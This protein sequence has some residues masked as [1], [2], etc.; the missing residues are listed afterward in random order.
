MRG[1][2]SKVTRRDGGIRCGRAKRSSS[3]RTGLS[4]GPLR[5]GA[6]FLPTSSRPPQTQLGPTRLPSARLEPLLSGTRGLRLEVS[7]GQQPAARAGGGLQCTFARRRRRSP[8]SPATILTRHPRSRPR[9][10]ASRRERRFSCPTKIR[11]KGALQVSATLTALLPQP[12]CHV[13][14]SPLSQAES[15]SR[16]STRV[17][18]VSRALGSGSPSPSWEAEAGNAAK[19]SRRPVDRRHDSYRPARRRG[20]PR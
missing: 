10:G 12:C 7:A 19:S 2:S 1:S 20:C 13:W 6:A 8:S 15:R 11:C 14:T 18:G 17:Y 4:D 5:P 16:G 3:I 9:T